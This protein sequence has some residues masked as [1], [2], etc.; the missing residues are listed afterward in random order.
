VQIVENRQSKLAK[1]DAETRPPL[2]HHHSKCRNST[3]CSWQQSNAECLPTDRFLD[4]PR[5][6]T[7]VHTPEVT[8]WK[9]R[10]GA[11]VGKAV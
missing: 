2:M 1:L 7:A 11:G 4:A 10:T 9:Y 3:Q 6:K 8:D 5:L